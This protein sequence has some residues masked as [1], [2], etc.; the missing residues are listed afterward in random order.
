[1]RRQQRRRRIVGDLA[2]AQAQANAFLASGD[3]QSAALAMGLSSDD[4]AKLQGAVTSPGDLVQAVSGYVN[5]DQNTQAAVTQL[6]DKNYLGALKNISKDLG[7][8]GTS[9]LIDAGQSLLSGD[10]LGAIGPLVAGALAATGVGAP[11][12][13]AVGGAIAIGEQALQMLGVGQGP[14]GCAWKLGRLCFNGV[15]PYGPNDP[16]WQTLAAIAGENTIDALTGKPA[17]PWPAE[18]VD[19]YYV[20]AMSEVRWLESGGAQFQNS[21]VANDRRL[22]GFRLAFLRS[23]L[24]NL[25]KGANGHPMSDPTSLL[26]TA[27]M[28]WNRKWGQG[29]GTITID[30]DAAPRTMPAMNERGTTFS[31]G[32]TVPNAGLFQETLLEIVMRGDISGRRQPPLSLAIAG[33]GGPRLIMPTGGFRGFGFRGGAPIVQPTQV[34]PSFRFA[35]PQLSQ[36]SQL[37]AGIMPPATAPSP[38]PA[39]SPAPAPIMPPVPVF[40]PAPAKPLG[41]PHAAV[42]AD[43]VAPSGS[44]GAPPGA[45][46]WTCTPGPDGSWQCRWV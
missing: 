3:P 38:G 35:T 31:P 37:P 39:P 27:A 28:A 20:T 42:L 24:A 5:L 2:G 10:L 19:H 46:N 17:A 8:P 22:D 6:A 21:P 15:R 7:I 32:Q 9:Q 43:A 16:Q 4:W 11:I 33:Q 41:V 45:T 1:M 36:L 13:A 25:E 23:Y 29:A 26:N 18:S 12:V 14:Q 44:P 30:A 40:A 34:V